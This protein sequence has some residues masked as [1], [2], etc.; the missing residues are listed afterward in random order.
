MLQ[1]NIMKKWKL[2]ISA[3]LFTS[4]LIVSCATTNNNTASSQQ[5][6]ESEQLQSVVE[7]PV[8]PE[9]TKEELFLSSIQN[10]TIKFTKSPSK[11]KKNKAFN[12][13]YELIVTDI[14]S[15]PVSNFEVALIIPVKNSDNQIIGT[16]ERLIT[17]ENGCLS[18]MPQV[19]DFAVK[20]TVAAYP[21]VP[22]NLSIN[23]K[24]LEPYTVYADFI[25]ES[26]I[27]QKGAIMFVFEYNE[28]GKAPKNSYDILSGLRKKGVTQIGN[29]P[30]DDTSY[31]NSSKDK[32]Y[33]EN[34]EIVG[35]DYGYLIGGTIKHANPVEQNEDGTYTAHMIAEIYGID[36]K[37]GKVI[38][39]NINE[40]Q[41]NGTNWNNAVSACKQK[42]IDSAVSSIMFGL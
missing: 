27:T 20:T 12:S 34:Y 21:F 16:R 6:N 42:L 38:Y 36:M 33:R 23:S 2:F 39:E 24:D 26:D 11:T 25:S 1:Y 22:D 3:F 4:G 13:A 9:P 41:E 32:I 17:D 18:Y 30:I 8:I 7:E 40:A 37:T 5:L 15:N 29:A 28:N 35:T 14:N 19:P 31:I 10:I